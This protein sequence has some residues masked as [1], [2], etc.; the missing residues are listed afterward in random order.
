[1]QLAFSQRRQK[2]HPDRRNVNPLLLTFLTVLVAL[3]V[4][5][6]LS[7]LK[8]DRLSSKNSSWRVV[9]RRN[10]PSKHR[11]LPSIKICL[12]RSF[13]DDWLRSS[14]RC[15]L[16]LYNGL[17]CRRL[18]AAPIQASSSLLNTEDDEDSLL[19]NRGS[20]SD[21]LSAVCDRTEEEI[22]AQRTVFDRRKERSLNAPRYS[23]QDLLTEEREKNLGFS[24]VD[25][26]RLG[27]VKDDD[28]ARPVT[29]QE[30]K[31]NILES[32]RN[33]IDRTNNHPASRLNTRQIYN[34]ILKETLKE[35]EARQKLLDTDRTKLTESSPPIEIKEQVP[36]SS[37]DRV[38][39]HDIDE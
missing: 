3:A 35:S 39:E 24:V 22:L 21:R 11:T 33:S 10:D 29:K 17:I 19:E 26:V 23:F 18:N 32:L 36:S 13:R 25:N 2:T 5:G 30:P 27:A 28:A 6:G 38:A 15:S 16:T 12:F 9:D 7:R 14:I 4:A 34:M 8:T 37:E 31:E 20:T 1:M